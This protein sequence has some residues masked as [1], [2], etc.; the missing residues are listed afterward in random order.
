MSA[1]PQAMMKLMQDFRVAPLV[2]IQGLQ[3]A[4]AM[5]TKADPKNEEII[6]SAGYKWDSHMGAYISDRNYQS[7]AA[8]PQGVFMWMFGNL[9]KIL[10]NDVKLGIWIGGRSNQ[11]ATE[12]LHLSGDDEP[13]Q[14]GGIQT[15]TRPEPP[16]EE[17][18]INKIL[19][20]VQAGSRMDA[21]R[22]IDLYKMAKDAENEKL[23]SLVRTLQVKE[24]IKKSELKSVIKE[25]VKGICEEIMVVEQD[26]SM[27]PPPTH[28]YDLKKGIYPT[29]FKTAPNYI[30]IKKSNIPGEFVVAW[31]T[32][33]RFNDNKSYYTNDLAD[34][35][36]TFKAMQPQVDVANLAGMKEQSVTGAVSP[37]T[38]S[39]AFKKKTNEESDDKLK[40]KIVRPGQIKLEGGIDP[41]L[42]KKI[43]NHHWYIEN[44]ELGS[45]GVWNFRTRG[46]A[47]CC[48]VGLLNGQPAI[49]S[50]IPTGNLELLV[51]NQEIFDEE[52]ISEMT[53]T[54]AVAGYNIPAAFARKGGSKR[55]VEGSAKLGYTLTSIGKKEMKRQGDNLE[56]LKSP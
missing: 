12:L 46:K 23:M 49:L 5:R 40:G 6:L 14:T 25:I 51:G 27:S 42:A 7:I 41:N 2:A 18:K 32:N 52:P 15:T 37:V 54:G 3:E 43:A 50:K 29:D 39:F 34:A 35:Y 48:A 55:G 33:G 8:L 44:S 9:G 36:K 22:I 26:D 38:T 56:E 17:D 45:D 31:F 1:N 24:N 30:R 21:D 4:L 10:K 11:F 13:I 19:K 16:S 20:T 28:L 47:Y 53:T